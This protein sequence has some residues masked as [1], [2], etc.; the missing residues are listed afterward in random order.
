MLTVDRLSQRARTRRKVGQT[1][2][3][4]NFMLQFPEFMVI[5][6]VAIVV[7]SEYFDLRLFEET[8]AKIDRVLAERNWSAWSAPPTR[9][10]AVVRNRWNT[11]II[12]R[13]G[14]P[15]SGPMARAT[16]SQPIHARD[17]SHAVSSQL[18]LRSFPKVLVLLS[19]P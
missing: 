15:S 4:A 13:L 2:P 19:C 12:G 16:G 17:L 18:F 14:R 7:V 5:Q 8:P 10:I 6:M 3:M 9:K 11:G 1:G